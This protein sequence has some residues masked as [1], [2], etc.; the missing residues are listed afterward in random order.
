MFELYPTFYMLKPL[1]PIG[2]LARPL[3]WLACFVEGWASIQL[4]A[5][6]G[7][8]ITDCSLY[9]RASSLLCALLKVGAPEP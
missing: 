6:R 1:D 8:G 7:S 3:K 5:N 4:D 2:F 9:A